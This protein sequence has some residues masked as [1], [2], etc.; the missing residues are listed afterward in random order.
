MDRLR[1]RQGWEGH[2]DRGY[3]D[4][5]ANRDRQQRQGDRVDR[6]EIDRDRKATGTEGTI[7]NT[8]IG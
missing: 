4:W 6:Q 3:R 2:R 1:E 7:D 8:E 5:I